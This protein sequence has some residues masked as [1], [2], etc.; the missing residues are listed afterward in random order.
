M[1]IYMYIYMHI[2][3]CIYIYIYNPQVLCVGS[4]AW[5]GW[6]GLVNKESEETSPPSELPSPSDYQ[7][8]PLAPLSDK[9]SSVNPRPLPK[10]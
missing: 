4:H 5:P 6:Q 3:I 1:H 10:P 2:Y 7:G 8:R 9:A